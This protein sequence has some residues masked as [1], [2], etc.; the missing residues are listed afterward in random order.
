MTFLHPFIN[1]CQELTISDVE[2]YIITSLI[3]YIDTVLFLIKILRLIGI[4]K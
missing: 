2:E 4:I 1:A 3:I